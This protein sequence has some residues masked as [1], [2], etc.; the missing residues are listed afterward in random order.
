MMECVAMKFNPIHRRGPRDRSCPNYVDCLE[1]AVKKAWGY[2][3]C[4]ECPYFCRQVQKQESS[5]NHGSR[6]A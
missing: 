3:D 6:L 1:H 5:A 4:R 2:W